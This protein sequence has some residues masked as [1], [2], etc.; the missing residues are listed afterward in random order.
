[1]LYHTNFADLDCFLMC[2]YR[3]NIFSYEY[4]VLNIVSGAYKLEIMLIVPT[5]L[6]QSWSILFVPEAIV[7]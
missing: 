6:R 5:V 3:K 7:L 1:M 2:F 4:I